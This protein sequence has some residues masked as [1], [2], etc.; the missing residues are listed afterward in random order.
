MLLLATLALA[1]LGLTA[2]GKNG[3][4]ERSA[5]VT[6]LS[7]E[8]TGGYPGVEVVVHFTIDPDRT[9][10]AEEVSWELRFG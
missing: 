10:S 1:M 9:T 5:E 3:D 8:P 2:C 7:V 4:A 6:I